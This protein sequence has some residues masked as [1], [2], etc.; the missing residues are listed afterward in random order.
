MAE[1][2]ALLESA[3]TLCKCIVKLKRVADAYNHFADYLRRYQMVLENIEKVRARSYVPRWRFSKSSVYIVNS[4]D[5]RTYQ[6]FRCGP[7]HPDFGARQ[8][9]KLSRFLHQERDCG[10]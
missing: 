4:L 7:G 6:G 2:Q 8:I 3:S 1:I 10:R 5:R 9:R